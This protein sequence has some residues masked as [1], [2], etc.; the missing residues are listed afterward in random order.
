[1][2]EGNEVAAGL[3]M[4]AVRVQRPNVEIMDPKLE[5][6]TEQHTNSRYKHTC[7]CTAQST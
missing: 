3:D 5:I 2:V 7:N 1:M 6:G 4:V